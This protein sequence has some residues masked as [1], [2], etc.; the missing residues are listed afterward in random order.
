MLDF[1][2]DGKKNYFI[3]ILS[4]LSMWI[5]VSTIY[6][7]FP[8]YFQNH[9]VSKS[10][11]G[12]LI[13]IGT[14]AGIIS[15]VLAGTYSDAHGRKPVLLAGVGLYAVV[16]FLFAFLGRGFYS[17]LILRFI[18]GFAF[19]MTPVVITA[20]VADV[21]P[22]EERGRAMALYTMSSG[23]GQFVG[24]LFAGIFIQASNF[25]T[26]FLLSG[27]FVVIS[28]LVIYIFVNE[29]LQQS[30]RTRI[31]QD[32]WNIRSFITN[33]KGLGK[34]IGLLFLAVVIY[35]MGVTMSNPFFS[36]YLKEDLGIDITKMGYF[37]AVRALMTLLVAPI[38]GT[39]ADKYGRKPVFLSGLLILV[40]TLMG[41]NYSNNF[42][43]VFITRVAQSIA[44]AMLRP[45]SR[46]YVAD[47]LTE[48]NRGFGLG[49]YSTFA[50]E[51]STIGAIFG[52]QIAESF[53]FGTVFVIGAATAFISFLIVL[54]MVPEPEKTK[55]QKSPHGVM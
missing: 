1:E 21:F 15:S 2:D 52:G 9:G 33:I 7:V 20:I 4:I 5:T 8:I 23:I 10:G 46:A 41:F 18:E 29:T 44:N 53:S 30:K 11:T 35:R 27:S 38:A 50:S 55:L 43:Q 3:L 13:A 47:L 51:S 48:E 54:V 14:F 24:P 37:F 36:L 6:M 45:S 12:I 31:F 42:I 22:P 34:V 40:T 16:F 28:W 32:S 17:F 25:F 49:L 39:M 26:Y 19:Y